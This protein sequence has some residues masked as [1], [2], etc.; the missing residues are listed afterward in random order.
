MLH[1]GVPQVSQ[2]VK[3]TS[4]V[5]CAP[6]LAGTVKLEPDAG[7]RPPV[8]VAQAIQLSP[9]PEQGTATAQGAGAA[10]PVTM[11]YLC[12]GP[13][14]PRVVVAFVT[15]IVTTLVW[16]FPSVPH[17]S[18]WAW[19]RVCFSSFKAHSQLVRWGGPHAHFTG[20]RTKAW[21]E[22][23]CPRAGARHRLRQDLNPA[24]D[25][26]RAVLCSLC[27]PLLSMGPCPRPAQNWAL[28]LPAPATLRDQLRWAS[29]QQ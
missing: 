4:G 16:R 1:L 6:S 3:D 14:P 15:V 19:G 29:H 12:L 28:P 18:G 21:T 11:P 7:L 22:G 17:V 10:G 5:L 25:N 9:E 23:T 13:P 24:P 27:R 26:S 2:S 20:G 8:P